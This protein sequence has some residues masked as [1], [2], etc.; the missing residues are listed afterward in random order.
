[1]TRVFRL[2]EIRAAI[3]PAAVVDAVEE[4]FAMY[5]RRE[6]VVP[7]V[8]LLHF[9]DPPGDVHIKYGY[10]TGDDYFV[11][12]TAT[13]FYDNP[14][15]GLPTG[16][17]T[18]LIGDAGT[19]A[20]LAILLDRGW[21]TE[22]RTGAAGAVAARHLA[23]T[24]RRIGVVGAGVQARFQV[25]ALAG[26]T[27]C[28]DL[29]VWSRTESRLAEYA[30]E[31]GAEGW[32]V[33]TTTDLAAVPAACNLIVTVTPAEHALLQASQIRSGTHITAVGSDSL[34][35]QELD[36]AILGAADRVVADSVAQCVHHGECGHA[37]AGG[38]LD[39]TDIVELGTVVAGDAPGRTAD[40]QITVADLTGVA[41]Q[42]IQVAKMAYAAL[43]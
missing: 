40:D 42:D 37:V 12:K 14:A 34:G 36:P 25:R 38:W 5:S 13:G 43:A 22:L 16:D 11:V 30:R 8:G 32:S 28:R 20:I 9:D 10:V 27:G 21:L 39:E 29:M 15:R 1:M 4:G 33:E 41:V 24:V 18:M 19:G 17:G 26:V 31:M 2:E 35:K 6:V 23:P 7:P 3:D